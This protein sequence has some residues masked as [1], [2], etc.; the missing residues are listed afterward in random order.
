[1]GLPIAKVER[2]LILA[3]LAE[4]GEKKKTAEVLGI[5]LKTLY[6]KLNAYRDAEADSGSAGD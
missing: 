4:C 5:S 2:R 1:V 3:T 6:N